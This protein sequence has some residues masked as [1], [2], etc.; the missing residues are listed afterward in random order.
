MPAC[1]PFPLAHIICDWSAIHQAMGFTTCVNN[2]RKLHYDVTLMP[3]PFFR[4]DTMK[5]DD[6]GLPTV[7]REP[8]APLIVESR[9]DHGRVGRISQKGPYWQDQYNFPSQL[10]TFGRSFAKRV[11]SF[12]SRFFPSFF[13]QLALILH[14]VSE[15]E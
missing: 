1:I 12:D 7:G 3:S 15:F 8:T 13:R 14:R 6:H 5:K 2:L 11:A 9:D 4:F 10:C